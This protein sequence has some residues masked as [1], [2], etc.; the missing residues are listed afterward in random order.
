MYLRAKEP[1]AEVPLN[2]LF[3]Q[4]EKAWRKDVCLHANPTNKK[5]VDHDK[6]R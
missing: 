2:K 4:A 3:E 1:S 6:R 5:R